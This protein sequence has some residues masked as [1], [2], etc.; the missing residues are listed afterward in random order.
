MYW[1][2]YIQFIVVLALLYLLYHLGLP[3]YYVLLM[4][5]LFILIIFFKGKLYRKVEEFIRKIF[6][7]FSKLSPVVK[8]IIIILAFI[9]IYFLIKQAL[10]FIL[11]LFGIDVQKMLLDSMNQSL[12]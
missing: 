10:F 6:P 4:G 9:L 5:L 2:I 3:L 11:K 7:S 8:K 12:S 1:K